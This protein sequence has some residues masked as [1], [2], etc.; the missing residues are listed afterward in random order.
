MKKEILTIAKQFRKKSIS[1]ILLQ[2]IE[3]CYGFP[4]YWISF[5]TPRDKNKILVGSHTPFNDN[6][7]Y[8]FL[9]T[10]LREEGKRVIWI[11]H[12]SDI[13]NEIK[14]RGLESYSRWSMKGLYHCLTAKIYVFCFHLIDI[15]FWTSGNTKKV[16]L[17]HGVPLKHIEFSV[18]TGSSVSV[19]NEKNIVSRIFAPYIFARPDRLISTSELITD[20][21]TEAFRVDKSRIYDFG[22]PRC[23]MFFWN[24]E[25]LIDYVKSYEPKIYEL[26]QK[27]NQFQKVFI[28][29][30]TWR[31]YD[32]MSDANID[33]NLLNEHLIKHNYYFFIKTHPATPINKE[34]ASKLSNVDILDND[35]D[36]YPFLPLTDC[37]ITDYSS[38]YYDYILLDKEVVLFPFD[39]QQYV[40]EDRGFVWDYAKAMQANRAYS[41]TSLLEQITQP[42][43]LSAEQKKYIQETYWGDYKGNSIREIDVCIN[44]I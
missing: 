30:P 5:I 33:L 28:Y 11:A 13:A 18:K 22:Q 2:L 27:I 17:W 10:G 21:Y 14:D 15:N 29:M 25:K 16:N 3:V 6:S 23:D 1:K 34:L 38:I 32:F 42:N 43:N 36:M 24:K 19:Y 39:E 7:K 4:L 31:D 35:I 9:L 26:S 12:N 20:Y 8:F 41:F 40:T 44:N 37:L